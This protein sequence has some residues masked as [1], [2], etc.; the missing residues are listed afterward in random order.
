MTALDLR[1]NGIGASGCAAL[2]DALALNHTLTSLWVCGNAI[3]DVGAAA[4]ARGLGGNAGLVDLQVRANGIGQEGAVA[5]FRVL[6]TQ[7]H[8]QHLNLEANPMG[9]GASGRALVA[10]LAANVTL[11]TLN[12]AKNSYTW[13][14]LNEECAAVSRAIAGNSHVRVIQ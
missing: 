14:D 13:G 8:L 7:P 5:L 1:W 11:R 2:A 3:G 6:Q 4:L 12:V 10:L 9:G